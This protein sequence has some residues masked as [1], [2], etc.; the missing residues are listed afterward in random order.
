MPLVA[1]VLLAARPPTRPSRCGRS[2]SPR[3]E[4]RATRA[5]WAWPPATAYDPE[6]VREA[7]LRLFATGDF[8]DVRGRSGAV[9][10]RSR[11]RLPAD[12]SRRGWP[13]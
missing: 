8:E 2:S 11:P 4:P 1:L 9:G 10:G 3:P 5:S 13:A 12:G 6:R 7:V